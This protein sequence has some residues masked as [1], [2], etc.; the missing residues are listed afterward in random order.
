[1]FAE[2][3]QIPHLQTEKCFLRRTRRRKKRIALYLPPAGGKLCEAFLTDSAAAPAGAAAF[4]ALLWIRRA[5]SFD[6]NGPVKWKY[7][8]N[9]EKYTE[10]SWKIFPITSVAVH[11]ARTNT[12]VRVLWTESAGA[13]K[14]RLTFWR[15]CPTRTQSQ[16][17]VREISTKNNGSFITV[18]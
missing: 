13:E 1:M 4:C 11:P 5:E 8:K 15:I 6:Q 12:N 10:Y 18:M 7:W 2:S 3:E 17:T 16:E 9:A 14:G